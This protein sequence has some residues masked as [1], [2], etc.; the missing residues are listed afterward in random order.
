M[1]AGFALVLLLLV[2]MGSSAFWLTRGNEQSVDD[3]ITWQLK[4]ERLAGEWS[5]IIDKNN[6]LAMSTTDPQL[7]AEVITVMDQETAKA[8]EVFEKLSPLLQ[9][10]EGKR[11]LNAA[12]AARQKYRA[13]RTEG[14]ELA[15]KGMYEQTGNFLQGK[16][17]PAT[18][19]YS[20]T[21]QAMADY[22]MK[23]IDEKYKKVSKD[24]YTSQMII[25]I[26]I[27]TSI[28]PGTLI[29]W[30][31]TRSITQP[32]ARTVDVA[33][34]VSAG[35]L[36]V[37]VQVHSR[38]EL[39][40]LM[41]SLKEMVRA[42]GTTVSKVHSGA[43]SIAFASDDI[44]AGN[45]DLA[46]R[47]EEQAASVEETAATLEQLTS[48]IKNTA[49]N[50]H[51]VNDLF[52][53]AGEVISSNSR[54]MH[55]VS[56]RMQDINAAAQKMTDIITVI[57]G[58]AFQTN[59]LALNAAVEAARAGE[60]GRDFAVVAGE[61]RTLAQRSSTSAKEIRDITGT[62]IN[63]ITGGRQVVNDADKEMQDIVEKVAQVQQLVDE[64]ARASTEQSD[65]IS[66]INVAMGQIDTTTQQNASLV[67]E[68][69][70]ATGSL[71]EQVRILL[72]SIKTFTLLDTHD[73]PQAEK[74][75]S[76]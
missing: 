34:K 60:Q 53:E 74:K 33:G 62:T 56:S 13:L 3:M 35:D 18:G 14:L 37:D 32:K 48:T 7:R 17:Y 23:L 57:E 6:G 52:S 10:A 8:T 11:L 75:R 22:Q 63:K 28:V 49:Q 69:S 46:S 50:A 30:F 24:S 16:F 29:A 36:R 68:S 61:V 27:I 2:M 12:L 71:K 67:K 70:A 47:T 44:D 59:I 58:I 41:H 20:K 45:R 51:R 66:Q 64:I 5:S 31:I 55:D 38:D 42:L 26:F 73:L 19:E 15:K 25:I 76:P 1:G 65:G 39:G 54:R 40:Q 72:E 43:E 21:L 4:K 9:L